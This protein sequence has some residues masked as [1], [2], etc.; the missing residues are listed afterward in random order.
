MKASYVIRNGRVIDPSRNVDKICDVIIQNAW[1]VEPQDEEIE[2]PTEFNVIDASDCIVTPGLVDHH[3]H[4]FY[5]GS[6]TTVYPDTMLASGVTTAIDAGTAGASTYRSFYETTIAHSPMHLKGYL[7]P[8]AGG[9]LD[10]GLNEDFNPDVWNRDL[11]A[12][13]VDRYRDSI[14]GLKIRLSVG[15]EP[16]DEAKRDI[17]G[18]VD[19]ADNLD[20]RLGTKLHVCVHTTNCQLPA[21]ELAQMLRPGDI[22]C[23]CYQPG[24]NNLILADGTLDPGVVEARKRGVIFDAAIGKSN[25]GIQTARKAFEL[26]F[27]PDIIATDA[28]ID[29]YNLPPYTKSL[30]V[31]LSKFISLG[32]SLNDVIRCATCMPATAMG[33][34]DKLGTLA[35]GAYACV[36]IFKYRTDATVHHQDITGYKFVGHE[37]LIPQMTFLDGIPVWSSTEFD[38]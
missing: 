6:G 32:M 30:P 8:W 13:L 19:L 12:R 22:F 18:M 25:F 5:E 2:T 14:I 10:V 24:Q 29:K 33:M 26:G 16:N 38:V 28:T 15:I 27:R 3:A 20:A 23:H 31:V 36:A 37:L 7:T 4:F 17:Q 35:P 1:I 21:G 34:S 11:I 9:Q